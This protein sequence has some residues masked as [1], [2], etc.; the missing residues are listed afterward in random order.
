MSYDTF[1]KRILAGGLIN[2]PWLD[3]EPRFLE[4]PVLFSRQQADE[5]KFLAEDVCALYNDALLLLA[6]NE[7]LA[8]TFLG[9]TATQLRMWQECK[10]LWHG[11]ARVDAFQTKDGWKVPELNSDTPT[12]IAEAVTLSALTATGDSRNDPNAALEARIAAAFEHYAKSLLGDASK[13]RVGIVYPT[14]FTEDLSLIRFYKRMFEARGY[15]V[16]LGSPYNLREENGTLFLFDEP[17][18]LLVRHYKTDWWS[19]RSSAWLDETVTDTEPL[20][21]PLHCIFRAVA[22]G[23][24]VVL[25]PFGSVITQNKRI[26]AFFWEHLH[27][28]NGKAQRTIE[29]YI[30]MTARLENLH[31]ELIR[32]QRIEWVL[33]SAYGAEGDQVVIGALTAPEVWNEVLA[34]TRVGLWVAQRYFDVQLDAKGRNTNVGVFLA[35]GKAAGLF[36]RLQHGPTDGSAL[37]APVLITD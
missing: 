31:I 4:Q 35:G 33:K 20:T 19:E 27:R 5:L 21:E 22:A 2:D 17:I 16:S 1:A 18:S 28:F 15:A 34:N 29:K 13:K 26:M 7:E 9:L 3:G 6:E 12:G 10:T 37:S 24:V 30:P 8:A 11:I 32:S 14:E 36:A 25:N 23:S